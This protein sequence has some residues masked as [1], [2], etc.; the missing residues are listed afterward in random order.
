MQ[1]STEA[2]LI[3]PCTWPTKPFAP[4]QS[5]GP[6]VMGSGRLLFGEHE[7]THSSLLNVVYIRT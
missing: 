5:C 7:Q 1:C 2:R 4:P 6:V 3:A